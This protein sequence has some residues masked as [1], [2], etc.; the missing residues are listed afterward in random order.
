MIICLAKFTLQQRLFSFPLVPTDVAEFAAL[1]APNVL[2]LRQRPL[3]LLQTERVEGLAA[4]PTVQK[5]M[6]SAAGAEQAHVS[7]CYRE[8]CQ[9]TESSHHPHVLQ[10][11]VLLEVHAQAVG[12]IGRFDFG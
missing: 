9:Y 2:L 6:M 7:R 11:A 3:G 5:L 4:H 12:S 8:R 1:A 10:V